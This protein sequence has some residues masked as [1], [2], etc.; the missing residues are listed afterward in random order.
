MM[1]N[2]ITV[3]ENTQIGEKCYK[4]HHKSGLEIYYIPKKL[5]ASFA[6]FS[7][8]YGSVDCRFRYRGAEE[9]T[10]VPD[11][12]AHFLEHKMFENE[13][14]T[15]TF[16]LFGRYGAQ[17]NAFTSFDKTSYLFSSTD[18]FYESLEVLLSFV[19]HPY[20]TP[21]TVAK[22]QGIIGQEI[23]MIAD[24]PDNALAFGMLGAMYRTHNVRIEIGGSVDSIAKITAPLLHECY[25]KFYNLRNMALCISG[26]CDVEKIL[27]ICDRVL[28]EAPEFNV[29]SEALPESPEVFRKTFTK[30][31]QVPTPMF[32][33]GVKDTVISPD[34]GDRMR[35]RAAMQIITDTLFGSSG[36]FYNTHYEDGSLTDG[37]D[38]W[39]EHN[40]S[41]SL[42]SI[43]GRSPD[44]EK[45]FEDYRAFIERTKKDGIPREDF[46]RCKKLTYAG[47]VRTF[48]STSG[49]AYSI[50]DFALDGADMLDYADVVG[51]LGYDEVNSLFR[52]MF[53]EE[54]T[55]YA[56]VLPL[57]S[58]EKQ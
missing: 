20:F 7:T 10:V 58:E 43:G 31:M 9:F 38:L 48:N 34:A 29:E 2:E 18:N 28:K 30:R 37:F 46:D 54:Y 41:F 4:I 55:S 5:T 25:E 47:F 1:K 11:G 40:R 51:S 53:R 14:G 22:E 44:P 21:E 27:G 32:S 6:V 12:I 50:M 13:D 45:L 26:D 39:S 52:E 36:E 49:I 24:N 3:K 17:A 56:T 33:I 35:K 16:E 15:D 23:A 19:T 8:R 57:E 42:V